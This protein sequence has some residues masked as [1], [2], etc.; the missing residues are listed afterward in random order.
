[1]TTFA[2][3][4]LVALTV[5]GNV[6]ARPNSWRG[7]TPLRSTCEDVRRAVGVTSCDGWAVAKYDGGTVIV[8]FAGPEPCHEKWPNTK[9]DVARGVVLGIIVTP[10][11]KASLSLRELGLI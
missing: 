6:E 1:M 8:T 11:A 7:I 10:K 4:V 9:W 5:Q 2:A 3:L